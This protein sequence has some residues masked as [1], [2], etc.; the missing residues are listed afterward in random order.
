MRRPVL[1]LFFCMAGGILSAYFLPFA[2]AVIPLAIAAAAAAVKKKGVLTLFLIVAIYGAVY[3]ELTEMNITPLE[4]CSGEIAEVWGRVESVQEKEGW[5]RIE[6]KAFQIEN[7]GVR[8]KTSEKIL[9][10]LYGGLNEMRST[11]GADLKSPQSLVGKDVY[12]KGEVSIPKRA[13]NP[14]LF[15]YQLYLR[16][17]GIN[18]IMETTSYHFEIYGRGNRITAAL[19][20]MKQRFSDRLSEE[21]NEESKALLIGMMFGDKTCLDEELLDDFRRN[22]TTHILAVSGIHVT[23]IFLCVNRLFRNRK[24][25]FTSLTAAAILILYAALSSFSP[26]VVRAVVMIL[27]CIFSKHLYRRYDLLCSAAFSAFLFLLYNPYSLFNTGF[28]LSYLAVFTM[29][30][31]LPFSAE[32]VE[33]LSGYRRYHKLYLVLKVFVPVFV[34]QI[35]MIPATAY[36]FQYISLTAFI[37][38]VPIIALSGII[39][40]AGMLLLILSF[41]GGM[42]FSFAATGTDLLIKLTALLSRS[43]GSLKYA[44]INMTAPSIAFLILFYGIGYF[45][46]SEIFW[47]WVRRGKRRNIVFVLVVS[48]CIAVSAPWLT[49]ETERRAS[50]VFV[51]VGQGD[52]IH[53]RTPEGK[54]I[55]IDGGGSVDY[56]V[57]KKILL[58]YL[59]KNGVSHIDL[60]CV[61]HLHQ[62]HFGGLI[63]LCHLMP[64]KKLA[65]YEG[66]RSDQQKILDETGLS[67][68]E[69]LYLK[70]GDSIDVEKGIKIDILYPDFTAE[71]GN[72]TAGTE[73]TDENAQ[74]LVIRADYQDVGILLT[75]DLGFPGEANIEEFYRGYV[76]S[77]AKSDILKIGHHGS[78]YST[79]EAFLDLVDPAIAVIQVGQNNFGHPNADVIEMLRKKDIMVERTDL[80]GAVLIDIK[81]GKIRVRTMLK[82]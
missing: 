45:L 17:R 11:L 79:G 31:L 42:L 47:D 9:L 62:D 43:T 60:A 22:G 57:G 82:E 48:F 3:F 18:T 70:K 14:G 46:V 56:D 35:G 55:L 67:P 71:G 32:K 64:V 2:A 59:L 36:L 26:S 13:T 24:T 23:V 74:T 72:E 12:L 66:N 28:Q 1:F 76:N 7:K 51:D 75:G 49:G 52:C 33:L 63:S 16:S 65:L 30:F 54:N 44:A 21:M 37:M 6:I 20:E 5:S 50:V 34:I 40:Q 61:T 81:N 69:L 38:N 73:E 39:I 25:P 77:P 10:Q 78:R 15:D 68:E 58:P 41:P 8:C 19:A 80:N 29:A 53:I 4:E 27:I